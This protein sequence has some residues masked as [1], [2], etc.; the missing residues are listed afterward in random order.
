LSWRRNVFATGAAASLE[1][2][3][4]ELVLANAKSS[5]AQALYDYRGGPCKAYG[6]NRVVLGVEEF[7]G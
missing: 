7:N 5:H 4:A 6:G 1:V 2:T 3:D